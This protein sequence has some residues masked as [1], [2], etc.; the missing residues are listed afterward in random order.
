M[1]AEVVSDQE[2]C[3][4]KLCQVPES[5]RVRSCLKVDRDFRCEG[6]GRL[7]RVNKASRSLT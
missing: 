1:K 5:C 3:R 7:V 6:V 4:V 2:C